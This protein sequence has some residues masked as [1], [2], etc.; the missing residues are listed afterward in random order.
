[1]FAENEI[2]MFF[3]AVGVLII[4]IRYYSKIKRINNVKLL[5]IGFIV[6]FA[7]CNFTIIEGFIFPR[8]FNFLEHISYLV[9]S[10]C[11]TIWCF[12]AGLQTKSKIQ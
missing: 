7:A 1:M 11:I 6:F 9:S 8:F 4:C 3:I 5:L 2:V 10:L 12:K